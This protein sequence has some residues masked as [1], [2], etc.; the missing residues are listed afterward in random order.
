MH[1]FFWINVKL[2]QENIVISETLQIKYNSSWN[3]THPGSQSLTEKKGNITNCIRKI[4][5][6]YDV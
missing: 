5:H 1:V 4:I 6:L 3:F 2:W